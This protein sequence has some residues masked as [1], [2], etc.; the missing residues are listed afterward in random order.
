M[1]DQSPAHIDDP[2]HVDTSDWPARSQPIAWV[3]RSSTLLTAWMCAIEWAVVM[4]LAC[5]SYYFISSLY[6]SMAT[7]A[8]GLGGI[9][10]KVNF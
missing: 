1:Q 2:R 4:L 3:R 8:A 6:L 7:R 5:T 10:E 9:A